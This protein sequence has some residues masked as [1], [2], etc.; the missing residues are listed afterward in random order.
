MKS[1][2]N[3][4]HIYCVV[5]RDEFVEQWFNFIT[6]GEI[7][8]TYIDFFIN[9]DKALEALQVLTNEN[10]NLQFELIQTTKDKFTNTW[11]RSPHWSYE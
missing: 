3:I 11:K 8:P 10:E 5:E 6:N 9:K 7:N 4:Q 2:M 1:S